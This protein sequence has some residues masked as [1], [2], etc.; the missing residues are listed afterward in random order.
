MTRLAD[1]ANVQPSVNPEDIGGTQVA[2]AIVQA[3]EYAYSDPQRAVTHNK[4]ILNGM[5]AFATAIG[6]DTRAVE[7]GAHYFAAR[8]GIYQPLSEW[9]MAGGL[10]NGCLKVPVP[11]GSIGGATRK[12][13]ISKLCYKILGTNSGVDVRE[14]CAAAG[15]AANLGVLRA[16]VTKGIGRA[17]K[18]QG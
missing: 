18:T 7:A 1:Y 12:S 14:I 9:K 8:E 2:E 4:G 3:T 13:K 10:L 5:I 6:N 16:L 15:L 17:H 11:L